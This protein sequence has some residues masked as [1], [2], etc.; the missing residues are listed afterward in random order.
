MNSEFHYS[1]IKRK[2]FAEE[3]I[4]R[5]INTYKTFCYHGNPRFIFVYKKI[6]GIEYRTFFDMEWNRLEHPNY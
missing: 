3:Y 6:E 2:V 1:L 4:G 5:D